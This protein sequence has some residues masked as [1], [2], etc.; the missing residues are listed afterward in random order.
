MFLNAMELLDSDKPMHTESFKTQE[1]EPREDSKLLNF[2]RISFSIF[3]VFLCREK[4]SK[5]LGC[6]MHRELLY[7]VLLVLGINPITITKG[8]EVFFSSPKAMS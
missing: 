5:T 1:K 7:V 4:M 8:F 6:S 2:Q 3:I